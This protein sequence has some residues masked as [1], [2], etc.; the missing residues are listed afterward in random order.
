MP[1]VEEFDENQLKALFDENGGVDQHGQQL[2][3]SEL[4][5]DTQDLGGQ[6]DPLDFR[7]DTRGPSKE[8]HIRPSEAPSSAFPPPHDRRP[9]SFDYNSNLALNGMEYQQEKRRRYSDF[10]GSHWSRTF[11]YPFHHHESAGDLAYASHEREDRVSS[12][13]RLTNSHSTSNRQVPTGHHGSNRRGGMG[14]PSSGSSA[15]QWSSNGNVPAGCRL[16]LQ[17]L[18]GFSSSPLARSHDRA[19]ESFP[20]SEK[21]STEPPKKKEKPSTRKEKKNLLDSKLVS[22]ILSSVELPS[23]TIF[24]GEAFPP[25]RPLS[26]YNYF[27]RD[28]R[29]RVLREGDEVD[30]RPQDREEHGRNL[31]SSHWN[32]DRR[33]KRSH[34]KT[35]GKVSF[36]E[37]SKIISDRWKSLG[38]D[39][40][41][42][43][44]QVAAIDM[45]RYKAEVDRQNGLN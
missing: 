17:G 2:P 39:E 40:Q 37:L 45:K 43:Y 36:T 9:D 22:Q 38:D 8:R 33:Q 5:V 23:T 14:M 12:S 16:L 34:R 27:F 24:H 28:E 18:E 20:K 35:H 41:E 26:A 3:P 15:T 31:L 42:F 7:Y 11:R 4:A 6:L 19:S 21:E 1:H 13:G 29:D 25:L 32:K 10:T 30:D 44:K